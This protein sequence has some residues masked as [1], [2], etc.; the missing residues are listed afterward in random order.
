MPTAFPE[1]AATP[2]PAP[3]FVL[4][5]THPQLS[6]ATDS[7]LL[8]PE[9]APAFADAMALA[10]ALGRLRD[11]EASRVQ[12]ATATGRAQGLAEGL[13]QGRQEAQQAAAAQLASSVRRLSEQS[14]SDTRALE[15]Q[16]VSLALLVIRR[17]AADLA[18]ETVLAALARQ[19]LEH[20]AGQRAG[21]SAVDPEAPAWRGCQL[22]LPPA[23][24]AAVQA[25]LGEV[26][27]LR[28]VADD[29]L[30]ALDCVLDTPAGRLLAGLDT[31]LNRVQARLAQAEHGRASTS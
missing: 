21:T 4:L 29:S 19:A 7:L 12:A 10:E 3:P 13:A 18:P 6:L 8:P 31:Q 25:E 9:Q 15:H 14:A 23:L 1:R 2:Q 5:H 20:L 22:R 11:D 26:P 17:I 30:A 28:L 16:L 24:L 27:G